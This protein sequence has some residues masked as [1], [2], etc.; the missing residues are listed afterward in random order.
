MKVSYT[1]LKD[2]VDIEKSPEEIASKLTLSGSEV[3]TIDVM[4][5]DLDGVIVGEIKKTETHPTDEKLSVCQVDV[6]KEILQIV[7][8]APNV[9]A[10]AKVP[11][12]LI[13]ARLFDGTKIKKANL[14]GIESFGMICSEVELGVG[15]DSQGIMIL[16]KKLVVGEDLSKALDLE[17]FIFNLD[18]TPNRP[19]CLSILGVAR[20]L[21]AIFG[22]ELRKPKPKVE[23]TDTPASSQVKVKI[24]EPSLC[25]RY[26]CRI[27]RGIKV[28][29]SPFWLR[30]RLQ[31]CGVRSIN[32]VVDVTNYVMLELGHPLHAFDYDLF[33]KFEV[34]VRKAKQKEKFVTL[35]EVERE[36]NPDIL[37]ITDGEKPVAIGG[38][39]GGLE[40]EVSEITKNVLLESAYFNP[41]MIRRGRL[42][43]G[44]ASESSYRFERGTDPNM[45]DFASNRAAELINELAGGE[46]LKG[47]V[48]NYPERIPAVKI[49][50]RTERVNQILGTELSSS[51]VSKILKSLEFAVKKDRNLKVEVPTFRPDVTRE[52]DL[53]EE[54][55]RIYGYDQI[56]TRMRSSGNLVTPRPK[57]DILLKSVRE[58]L[59]GLG[60]YEVITNDLVDPEMMGKVFSEK[61]LVRIQNPLSEDMSVLRTSL[62]YNLLSVLSHNKKRREDQVRIFEIGKVFK[63]RNQQLPEERCKIGIALSGFLEPVFWHKKS[64]LDFFYMKGILESFFESLSLDF[65]IPTPQRHPCFKRDRGFDL[66]IEEQKIG[67]LGEVNQDILKDFDIKDKVF[68]CEMDFDLL[69]SLVTIKRSYQT[70]PKYPPVDRDI[71]IVVDNSVLAGDVEKLVK[72]TGGGVLEKVTLF[73]LYRG[74]QIPSGKKSLA[75]S[76]RYRSKEKTLTDEGVNE[77]HS[78]IIKILKKE[79]GADLRI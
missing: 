66:R 73:D 41:G 69:L 71:A 14:K 72:K 78:E 17:D 53:I 29:P 54:V 57:E 31:A 7:C 47:V 37:L 64:C 20:E 2:F 46:L 6:G 43:L 55:A 59:F 50:L 68:L 9:E 63:D 44:I 33:S 13:G 58:I 79:L 40:S 38:I 60:L 51:D 28:G 18:L 1:W 12:A 75:Y 67:V 22:L 56:D 70:L 25:P 61:E 76:L 3:E 52:I 11:V 48:D 19:D 8:G 4:G 49:T 26:T 34:V 32:N 62:F 15:E 16:N 5:S 39:M 10:K 65:P 35:D 30:R 24:D 74:D 36:L 77:I 23:E 27:I 45:V 42:K 21:S